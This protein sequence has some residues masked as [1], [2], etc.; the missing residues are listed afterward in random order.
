MVDALSGCQGRQGAARIGERQYSCRE[1]PLKGV[2]ASTTLAEVSA[3]PPPQIDVDVPVRLDMATET[4]SEWPFENLALEFS[5]YHLFKKDTNSRDTS[6]RF[7]C[8]EAI[9]KRSKELD[10]C[11]RTPLLLLCIGCRCR[12]EPASDCSWYLVRQPLARQM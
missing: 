9:E 8:R 11:R 5:S 10:R 4:G 1:P 3:H 7:N 6:D 2:V 12:A